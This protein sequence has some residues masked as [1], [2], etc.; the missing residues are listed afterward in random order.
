MVQATSWSE[1]DALYRKA[2][3]SSPP[4]SRCHT[5]PDI[6]HLTVDIILL[7]VVDKQTNLYV[8]QK[9]ARQSNKK[10]YMTTPQ[11]MMASVGVNIV[12]GI[13]QK[14]EK[15]SYWLT[16]EYMG[17]EGV[18]KVFPYKHFELLT[19]YLHLSDS[20]QTPAVNQGQ[21]SCTAHPAY[22]H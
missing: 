16:N 4:E 9:Q 11:E 19:R 14:P 18:K 3:S 1:S 6:F 12:V 2:Q 17:N 5:T 22:L 13:D 15:S 21:V 10:W 7:P 20:I 8:K